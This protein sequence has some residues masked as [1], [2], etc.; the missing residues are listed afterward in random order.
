MRIIGGFFK[1]RRFIPPAKNWPTRPTTD[2][3]KEGLFNILNNKIDFEEVIM[4]DL[5]GGTGNHSYEFISRGCTNV[6]YVDKF[7]GC[8]DF[9]QKTAG[10]LKIEDKIKIIRSD[11]FRFLQSNIRQFDY[12]FAGPPYPLPN[13]NTIPDVIFQT[14]TL[15]PDGLFVM[16]HNPNH[17]FKSHNRFVEARNYGTTIF[18]FFK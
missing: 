8:I 12:I 2:F 17:D 4:L 18:S 14:E 5:F 3:A 15:A 6:T 7:Q 16:E 9:V 1:G 10:E 13:L 11:V